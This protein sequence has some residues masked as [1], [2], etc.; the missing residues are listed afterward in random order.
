MTSTYETWHF[1]WA[2]LVSKQCPCAIHSHLCLFYIFR[3][4]VRVSPGHFHCFMSH[5]LLHCSN[6]NPWQNHLRTKRILEIME[7]KI[8]NSCLF[9]DSTKTSPCISEMNHINAKNT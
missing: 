5:N 8:H 9:K 3:W 1:S 2:S 4:K 6:I 7:T